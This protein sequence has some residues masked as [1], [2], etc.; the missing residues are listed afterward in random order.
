VT[1]TAPGNWGRWGSEDELGAFNVLT[2][3]H[4]LEAVRLVRTGTVLPLG[5]PLGP[6]TQVPPHRKQ[7]ERFMTR[8][9]GDYAA[10]ARRIGGF[11]FAEEVL[12]FAAHSGTHMDALSH[13]WSGDQLYNGHPSTAIRSTTGAGKC[14]AENLRPT[15]TRGVLIDLVASEQR[16]LGPHEAVGP[17]VL[18]RALAESSTALQPGDAVLIRTGWEEMARDD[19]EAY[20]E[21]E[22][23]ISAE[24]ALWLAQQDI[25][26]VGADNYAVEVQ[27]SPPGTGF[28]AHQVLIRD[29]GVPLVEGM[30]L[31][32]LASA[33]RPEFLLVCVPNG[34]V[35]GTA[36][37]VCPLAIL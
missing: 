1:G 33:G 31:A 35:G 21:S 8:D 20:F 32:E 16:R 23:G 10:G 34:V 7:V 12:S 28:P 15:V 2:A 37:Q 4:V 3:G 6:R 9:G 14:G 19:P 18:A 22:P 30:V 24:A 17:D 36:A 29:F 27:P 26:L 25:V 5:Q 13:A 11:Q